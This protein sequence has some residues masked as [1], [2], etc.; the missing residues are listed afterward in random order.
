MNLGELIQRFRTLARDEAQPH[1]WSD[2]H[3]TQWL[4]DA[5]AQACIRG[6]LLR[7]D[8]NPLVCQ[9]ALHAGQHTWPLHESV[10]E[11]IHV[12]IKPASGQ[13]R[14]LCLLSR[15]LLD[16]EHAGWRDDERPAWALIQDETTVR[17]V[18]RVQAGD[19]L[20]LECYRLP[21]SPMLDL[22]DTPEIHIAHHEYLLLWALYRAF[23]VVDAET[24]D[25]ARA[26]QAERE[27]SDYFGPMTG[28]NLRRITR[29]DVV[30][31][32]RPDFAGW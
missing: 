11:L 29:E 15:E 3:V 10:Y 18:G 25:A 6:R 23:S 7:E 17:V 5:Q 26:A 20:H 22:A 12:Q 32:T 19:V 16:A 21:L 8:E 30:H 13:G 24:L 27:F 4:N 2:A 1:L 14:R 28:S 31:H 9:I